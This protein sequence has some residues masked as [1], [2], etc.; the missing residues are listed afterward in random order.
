MTLSFLPRTFELRFTLAVWLEELAFLH[1]SLHYS[2][3]HMQ[4]R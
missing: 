3:P 2:L 1:M 4:D